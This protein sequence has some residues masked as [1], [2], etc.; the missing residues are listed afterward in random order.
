MP[1]NMSLLDYAED[2]NYASSFRNI[3]PTAGLLYE[4]A[5]QGKLPF[6]PS[7]T[8]LPTGALINFALGQID[9]NVPWKFVKEDADFYIQTVGSNAGKVMK[10]PSANSV[11]IQVDQELLVPDYL[12]YAGMLGEQSGRFKQRHKGTAQPY[13]TQKDIDDVLTEI[14]MMRNR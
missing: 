4:K 13:I 9:R 10:E 12:Y 14:L 2:Q 6:V 5:K 7:P 3:S 1:D 8:G 11:G